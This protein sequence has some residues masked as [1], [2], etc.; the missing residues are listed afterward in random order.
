MSIAEASATSRAPAAASSSFY[1]AMRIL[2]RS[3]RE[4]MYAVYAFCRAVDDIADEPG[5]APERLG[6]LGEWRR[7]LD[8]L[9]GG[10]GVTGL[11][12]G[13]KAPVEM[14]GLRQGDFLAVIDGMELDVRRDRSAPD[15]QALDHY[16]D[17]V[18][19]AVGRLSTRIFGLPDA[20][21]IELSHHLGRALQLTNILRDLDEDAAMGR[22]YLPKEALADARIETEAIADILA[23]PRL[24]QACRTVAL[25]ARGHFDEAHRVMARLPRQKVRSPRLMGAVYRAILGQLEQR[26]WGAPRQAT[27]PSKRL[28]LWAIVWHGLF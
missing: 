10:G 4:A 20:D 22:L 26:G 18:A 9:Y 7:D 2:P 15:W 11:T 13:L 14:F 3:Q 1:A 21:G 17:C 12:Q 24:D 25:R 8:R 23:H 5:P 27:R 6:Q 19:S 28:I 16:C